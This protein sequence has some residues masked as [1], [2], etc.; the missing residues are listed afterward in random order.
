MAKTVADIMTTQVLTLREE[1]NLLAPGP[2]MELFGLR[3]LPVVDGKRLVGLVSHSDVLRL[4]MSSL[5]GDS[6]HAAVDRAH[7]AETFVASVM[8]RDLVVA[9]PDVTVAEAARR[10]VERKV[11][12]LPVVDAQGHLLGIVTQHD[13]LEELAGLPP[14][15]SSEVPDGAKPPGH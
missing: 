11:G 13:L 14:K 8:T 12:C 9:S 6:I 10:L 15:P 4:A 1:D 7:H 5:A 3:H 2:E